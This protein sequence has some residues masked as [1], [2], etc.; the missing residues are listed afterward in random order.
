MCKILLQGKGIAIRQMLKQPDRGNIVSISTATTQYVVDG[1]GPYSAT[2]SAVNSLTKQVAFEYADE[3]IRANAVL[4][5]SMETEAME[6]FRTNDPVNYE[7]SVLR[8]PL[9][10]ISEPADIA[11]AV[12][13]LCSDEAK[14]VTGQLLCYDGG[15]TL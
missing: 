7:A 11:R 12:V 14:D 4:P 10:R 5:G 1:L 2:K 8:I 15:L 9:K 13:W 3:N 6:E